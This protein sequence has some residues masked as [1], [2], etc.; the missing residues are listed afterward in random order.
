VVAAIESFA[1]ARQ[2]HEKLSRLSPGDRLAQKSLAFSCLNLASAHRAVGNQ[3]E[4]VQ[5]SRQA[6]DLLEPIVKAEPGSFHHRRALAGAYRLLGAGLPPDEALPLIR[7]G[8]ALLVRLCDLE[9]GAA[10]LQ[11][12][13]ASS[14]RLLGHIYIKLNRKSEALA[15]YDKALA[16]LEPVTR[17]HPETIDFRNDLARCHF[18]RGVTQ[19]QMGRSAEGLQSLTASRDL[20]RALVKANPHNPGFRTALGLT[21]V[22]LS[23]T[24]K[25]LGRP[26]EA[27]DAARAAVQEYRAVFAAAPQF[28]RYRKGLTHALKV[29]V[30]FALQ[31]RQPL[32]AASTALELKKLWPTNGTELYEAAK[33]LGHAATAAGGTSESSTW[34]PDAERYADLAVAALREAAAA[35]LPKDARPA[36]Y[37]G[38]ACLRERRD[39][40][41]F[42]AGLAGTAP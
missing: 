29:R 36:E 37:P 30:V 35:G 26:R 39:F 1:Q 32:E 40:Q 25:D 27:L 9:P 34:P 31:N 16:V 3:A 11:A 12:E 42:L 4:V 7:K 41:D 5:F 23:G 28:L 14:H 2:I 24:L 17:K 33:I 20:N 10:N 22:N 19:W 38:F 6:C 8:Q 13:L 15:E 18:D 21:L